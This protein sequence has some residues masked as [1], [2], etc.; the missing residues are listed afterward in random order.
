MCDDTNPEDGASDA[1][2]CDGGA[3]GGGEGFDSDED[4]GEWL[5]TD[6]RTTSCC[7]HSFSTLSGAH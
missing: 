5:D 7:F 1:G 6:E 2:C 4:N 3:V